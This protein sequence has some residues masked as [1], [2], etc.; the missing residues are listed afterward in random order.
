[1]REGDSAS[2]ARLSDDSREELARGVRLRERGSREEARDL[3]VDLAARHPDDAEIAY[4]TAWVHDALGLEA[5][6]VAYYE[7]ALAG[8]G[9]SAEDRLGAFTGLGSTLR[10]LGRYGEALAL[11]E[12]GLEEFPGDPGLRTF[13]AMA[14]YNEGRSR[15]AVSGLLKLLVESGGAGRYRPAVEYYADHLDE[16]VP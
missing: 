2:V 14:L 6:A 8:A 7:R 1:M 11:F 4:Q 12:R 9:L 16:T 5:E 3:L 10:V 13:A 15:E